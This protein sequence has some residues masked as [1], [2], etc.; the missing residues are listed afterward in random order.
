MKF[1]P[2]LFQ[3]KNSLNFNYILKTHL[4]VMFIF[5]VIYYG[6]IMT[7]KE[8]IYHLRKNNDLITERKRIHIFLDCINFS[9]VVHTSTGFSNIFPKDCI[10]AQ[11]IVSIHMVVSLLLIMTL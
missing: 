1:L 7:D 2:I 11:V 3:K 8:D 10:I 9:L 4:L 5:S 6:I